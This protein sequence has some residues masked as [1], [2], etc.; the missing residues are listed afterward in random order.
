MTDQHVIEA[1][2]IHSDKYGFVVLEVNPVDG[3]DPVYITSVSGGGHLVF[4]PNIT[5]VSHVE[6]ALAH[7]KENNNV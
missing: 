7:W 1:E 3:F 2:T 6:A 5:P 4:D